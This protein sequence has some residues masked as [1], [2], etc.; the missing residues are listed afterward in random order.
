[1]KEEKRQ[2][3]NQ[4][5]ERLGRY[6]WADNRLYR[7]FKNRLN[8]ELAQ[9]DPDI[10]QNV[11]DQIELESEMLRNDC[12]KPRKRRSTDSLRNVKVKN[13]MWR[14]QTCFMMTQQESVVTHTQ[15]RQIMQWKKQYPEWRIRGTK[16]GND[17]PKFCTP[18]DR[19]LSFLQNL[20][21]TELDRWSGFWEFSR[22]DANEYDIKSTQR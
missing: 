19:A 15:I 10:V 13:S 6:N 21:E 16:L 9:Y 20:A 4:D 1:M 5:I 17:V 11:K 8:R 22:F 12:L 3:S 18:I 7:H 2:L 14:N